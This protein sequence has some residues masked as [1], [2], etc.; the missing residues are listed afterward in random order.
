MKIPVEVRK[1]EVSAVV[2]SFV[3]EPS[4]KLLELALRIARNRDGKL[5][6]LFE[7]LTRA[8]EFASSEDR[9]MSDKD[10]KLASDWRLSGGVWP[11]EQF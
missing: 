3:K 10:L 5:R 4:T 6:T 1:D 8:K 2:K 7:D 9:E 11:D